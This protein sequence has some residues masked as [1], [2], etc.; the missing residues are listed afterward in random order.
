[1]TYKSNWMNKLN[2]TNKLNW[3]NKSN[4]MNKLNRMSL[5]ITVCLVIGI[6]LHQT[7]VVIAGVQQHFF[8]ISLYNTSGEAFIKFSNISIE[9]IGGGVIVHDDAHNIIFVHYGSYML[10]RGE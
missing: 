7:S 4:W 9:K 5:G 1:M 10:L 2:R 8:Q 6:Y 3:M